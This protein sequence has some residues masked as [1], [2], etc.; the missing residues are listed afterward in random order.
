MGEEGSAGPAGSSGA[1]APATPD[2]SPS[3]GT[4]DTPAGAAGETPVDGA[5]AH[6]TATE[7]SAETVP[8]G[9]HAGPAIEPD[10][11][12]E[13]ARV[14]AER[15]AA[16]AALDKEGRKSRRHRR[17]RRIV[18]A[19]LVVLFCIL[20]PVTYVVTWTHY[21]TLNS[22]GFQKAVGPLASDPA[23]QAAA[24][25]AI[26]N[27]IFDSLNPQQI[28]SNAL[29]PKASFLAAPV[30]NAV[31]GYVETAVT[32][33]LQS[34]QFQTIWQQTIRVVHQELL[35]ALK[36]NSKALTTTNG[37]VVL[38]L[39]PLL[40]TTLQSMQGFV[41]GLVGHPVNLPTITANEVPSTACKQIGDAIGRTLPENCGQIPLF[42][43]K[44]LDTARRTV[45]IFDGAMILLLILTPVIAALALWVSNRKRR[46]LLQLSAGGF[47]GLVV[48]RRVVIWLDNALSSRGIPANRP[49]RHAL[50]SH[51]FSAYFSVSRWILVGLLVVFLIAL[52]TGPYAWARTVR[53]KSA[54]YGKKGWE[55]AQLGWGR[56]RDDAT[57][58]WIR[59]HL[60]LLRVLGVALAIILLLALSVSWIGFIVII[61][62]LAAYEWWLYHLGK[63]ARAL[64]ADSSGEGPPGPPSSDDQPHAPGGAG[65]AP[66]V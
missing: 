42:P 2:S 54:V 63:E 12:L 4:T 59:S 50:V 53:A 32:K 47:L 51:L 21:V 28:V 26:T 9:E 14:E 13:L 41:S 16:V 57:T 29:P 8:V 61:V 5:A 45:K 3:A 56:A 6:D 7:A 49:A 27:Q 40:N 37:Q 15:D 23:I 62:L 39:V 17:Y 48:I 36:G 34:D 19:V 44:Q 10:V 46:T 65:A 35:A 24:S 11:A 18:A 22:N 30:T 52:V 33:V 55:V 38:N 66:A 20:L 64:T 60:D 1:G 31:R 58:R 25:T 43:S